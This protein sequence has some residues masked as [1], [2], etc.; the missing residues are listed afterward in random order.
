MQ[1]NTGID[2]MVMIAPTKAPG[3]ADERMKLISP[4]YQASIIDFGLTPEERERTL[5]E[6]RAN[7]KYQQPPTR[8]EIAIR[9]K[10]IELNSH[11]SDYEDEKAALGRLKAALGY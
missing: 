4:W 9:E 10:G 5:A 7:P 2:R 11:H 3:E 8:E 6:L 1:H